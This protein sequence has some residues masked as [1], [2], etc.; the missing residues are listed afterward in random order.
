M[1]GQIPSIPFNAYTDIVAKQ[2]NLVDNKVVKY[3]ESDTLFLTVNGNKKTPLNP[4]NA[5]VRFQ[6]LEI[7]IRL[8]L[9]RYYDCKL[10][11]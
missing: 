6:F 7:L 2:L 1:G 9:K 4:A 5:L 11:Q 8:G 10:L 3:A